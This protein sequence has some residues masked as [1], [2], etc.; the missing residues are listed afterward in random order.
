MNRV[1]N[2]EESEELY[3]NIRKI[4]YDDDFTMLN[5]EEQRDQTIIEFKDSLMSLGQR[6]QILEQEVHN[7]I[8]DIDN[9]VDNQLYFNFYDFYENIKTYSER[10]SY[11]N[12]I[13]QR[14]NT[15]NETFQNYRD[16]ANNKKRHK[17]KQLLLQLIEQYMDNRESKDYNIINNY[18]YKYSSPLIDYYQININQGTYIELCNLLKL[19]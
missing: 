7:Y 1:W 9:A 2:L 17:H 11:L 14:G 5:L 16:D 12:N 3:I 18:N 10:C 13:I 6:G 4:W 19:L 8:M 15:I